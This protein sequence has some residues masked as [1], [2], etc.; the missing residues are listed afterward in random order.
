M[1]VCAAPPSE[2]ARRLVNELHLV[3]SAL[4]YA[5]RVEILS[6]S[7]SFARTLKPFLPVTEENVLEEV[8]HM[9]PETLRRLGVGTDFG[10]GVELRKFRRKL[11]EF[12]RLA[13]DDPD[14]TSIME[15]WRP[16]A[17][18]MHRTATD[19]FTQTGSY[20]LEMAFEREDVELLDVGFDLDDE[21]SDL[22]ETFRD[23]ML[24]A[25]KDSKRAIL[26][27][28]L[29]S[30]MARIYPDH[31]SA[32][33]NA[34]ARHASTGSGLIQRLP[35]FPEASIEHI[36]EARDELAEGRI[37]YRKAVKDLANKLA[38]APFDESMPDEID[39]LWHDSVEPALINLRKRVTAT[40][41]AY[42][43]GKSLVGS[44]AGLVGALAVTVTSLGSLADML[45]ST[46]AVTTGGVNVV[47]AG[48]REALRA[49]AEERRYELV[50]LHDV[51]RSLGD[52]GFTG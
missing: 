38:S 16:A 14:R 40:R 2:D 51:N 6:P 10:P 49:R 41:I 36:L 23:S 8:S 19:Y 22:I 42:E 29:A 27:D 11:R 25:L 37:G 20:E 5:D 21:V 15:G 24:A 44:S 17:L 26:V 48:A 12:N 4:L 32:Y 43:A 1:T 31:G 30:E 52:F 34:R 47:Y 33:T 50:Y 18:E 3:K 28:P 13:E 46:A 7:S 35:T 45:P 39:E 9:P